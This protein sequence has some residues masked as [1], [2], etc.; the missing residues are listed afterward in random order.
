MQ[1]LRLKQGQT[2]FGG[3][4]IP[5]SCNPA[6]LALGN[7]VLRNWI[8][9]D[10]WRPPAFSILHRMPTLFSFFLIP[11]SIPGED[12]KMG[13]HYHKE[14][15]DLFEALAGA[16]YDDLHYNFTKFRMVYR[17]LMNEIIGINRSRQLWVMRRCTY[18]KLC[19][20]WLSARS[21]TRNGFWSLDVWMEKSAFLI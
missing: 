2:W 14:M 18:V 4:N 9:L 19:P 8:A 10:P 15:A 21:F 13:T 20:P 1:I 17:Q 5:E 3:I 16:V 6:L 7:P 12:K 11:S